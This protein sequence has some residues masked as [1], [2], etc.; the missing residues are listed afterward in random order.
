MK[1]KYPTEKETN[2]LIDKEAKIFMIFVMLNLLSV[3]TCFFLPVMMPLQILLTLF[4][5]LSYIQY[6][7]FKIINYILRCRK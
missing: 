4:V 6:S 2:E 1:V 7:R 3:A 5:I